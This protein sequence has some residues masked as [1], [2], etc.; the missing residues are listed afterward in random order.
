MAWI[1]SCW[2]FFIALVCKSFFKA[3]MVTIV[4]I[5]GDTMFLKSLVF[6]GIWGG[7]KLYIYKT[8]YLIHWLLEYRT[9]LL[10]PTSDWS[11]LTYNKIFGPS[12]QDAIYCICRDNLTVF[13]QSIFVIHYEQKRKIDIR[14][15][16]QNLSNSK[17][18]ISTKKLNSY[19][20]AT[21]RRQLA[22]LA[23]IPFPLLTSIES[24]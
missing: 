3:L 10:N 8:T 18:K 24:Y 17:I 15:I 14:P 12:C 5:S 13:I 7:T 2:V 22:L 21:D 19:E 11:D 20:W 23:C 16:I 9:Y 6:Q 1:S 4:R